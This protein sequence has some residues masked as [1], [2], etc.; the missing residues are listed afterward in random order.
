MAESVVAFLVGRLR[1]LLVDEVKL[2]SGIKAQVEDMV[3]EL[4]CIQAFLRVAD[5]KEDSNPQL[6]VWVKQVR[7]VAHQ[8][9]DALDK[10][11]L[12][13]SHDVQRGLHAFLQKLSCIIMKPKACHHIAADIQLLQLN[14]QTLSKGHNRY[15]LYDQGL[16]CQFGQVYVLSPEEAEP[17]GIG[18]RKEK[19]IEMLMLNVFRQQVVPV[20]GMGGLGKLP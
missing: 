6:I 19:L 15:Q 13:N 7:D 4:E 10:F 17:V 20:V 9:E 18:E 3:E 16:Q 1:T 14:V 11:R 2:L 8:M 12:S 5:A